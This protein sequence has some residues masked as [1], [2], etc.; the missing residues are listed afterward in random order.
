[1]SP[2]PDPPGPEAAPRAVVGLDGGATSAKACRVRQ[3]E[4]G[5]AAVA[6]P[7]EERYLRVAG[8]I[9]VSREASLS[10][11]PT[12]Q[13]L[14]AAQAWI[15]AAARAVARAAGPGGG[16]LLGAAL[17][18]LK[19]PDGRGLA[20]ARHGP[21]IPDYLARLESEL[22]AAGVEL[23]AP[24]GG[25][26]SDGDCCGWGEE[27]AEQGLFRGVRNAWYAGGGTGLAEAFKLGGQPVE[28]DR[29]AARLQKGWQ[30][31][32][33]DG[34]TFED[35]L[36]LS[37]LNAR[38]GGP[39]ETRIEAPRGREAVA[40]TVEA[41]AEL[42]ARRAREVEQAGFGALERVVVGQRLGLLLASA[43]LAPAR[44]ALADALAARGLPR[45]GWLMLSRLR[46]APALGAAAHALAAWE[47]T[48][49]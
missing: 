7:A 3:G 35:A 6:A 16:V 23:L 44:A 21:R 49:A 47:A 5:L 42:A 39:V 4:Q 33:R 27:R 9:P 31:P 34:L 20:W 38:A 14:L 40:E 13:E 36:S 15:A 32:W 48:R 19:T 26:W 28:M 37:G 43:P 41:L 11:A 46:E 17:P 25:L 8:F 29:M 18:G 22:A 24:A 1:M 30:I 2:V 45:T 12:A 10:S